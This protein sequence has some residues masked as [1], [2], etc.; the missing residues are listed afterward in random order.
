MTP[1]VYQAA[2]VAELT[3]LS[4]WA[5]YEAARRGDTA[6]GRL[7]VRV[8]RRVVWPRAAVDQLFQIAASS[9]DGALRSMPSAQ[10]NDDGSDGDY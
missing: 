8:G 3:S 7:A 4:E 6:V 1:A 10:E 5:V 9:G 2:E